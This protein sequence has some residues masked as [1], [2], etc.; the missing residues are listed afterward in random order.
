MAEN[1]VELR[2]AYEWTCDECGRDSFVGGV[3]VEV[4]EQMRSDLVESGLD[5]PPMLK[6]GHWQT[7]PEEV[8][9]SHCGESFGTEDIGTCRGED[10]DVCG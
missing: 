7:Q 4:D 9:C 1:K 2:P 5:D 8:T 6:T 3:I 10:E